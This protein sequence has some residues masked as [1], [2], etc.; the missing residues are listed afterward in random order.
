MLRR[1]TSNSVFILLFLFWGMWLYTEITEY[2]K[3][4]EF[5]ENVEYFIQDDQREDALWH[6]LCLRVQHLETQHHDI[7]G[8]TCGRSK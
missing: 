6:E 4:T 8:D 1:L 2:M 3:R 5:T 7:V